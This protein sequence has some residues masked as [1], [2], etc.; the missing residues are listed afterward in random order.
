MVAV[1]FAK[2]AEQRVAFI[3]VELVFLPLLGVVFTN[4]EVFGSIF[5]AHDFVFLQN[6]ADVLVVL[7]VAAVAEVG[8]VV[9]AMVDG[10]VVAVFVVTIWVLVN[11]NYPQIRLFAFLKPK[12]NEVF[13]KHLVAVKY[14]VLK[15]IKL[16]SFVVCMLNVDGVK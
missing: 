3:A 16:A 1:Y 10:C 6:V 4:T 7:L 11:S 8:V 13:W 2:N 12:F 5:D 14:F 15:S 9:D